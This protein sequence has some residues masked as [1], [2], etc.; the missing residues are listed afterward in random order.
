MTQEDYVKNIAE[1]LDLP[2]RKVA[3]ALGILAKMVAD[4]LAARGEARLH[5]LVSFKVRSKPARTAR[6][7]NTGESVAVPE[8]KVVAAKALGV[9][10]SAVR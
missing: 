9:V 10:K 3:Q 8:R 4:D 5:G 6:N 1:Q 2:Q 7:P